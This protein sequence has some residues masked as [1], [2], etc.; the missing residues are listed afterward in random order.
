M[1]TIAENQNV[2]NHIRLQQNHVHSG[3]PP[4]GIAKNLGFPTK[5]SFTWQKQSQ[6]QRTVPTVRLHATVNFQSRNKVGMLHTHTQSIQIGLCSF[7]SLLQSNWGFLPTLWAPIQK[8]K[9][10]TKQCSA[11]PRP[12]KIISSSAWA[13]SNRTLH[14]GRVLPDSLPLREWFWLSMWVSISVFL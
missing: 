12:A 5:Q 2:F 14:L 6:Y 9:T 3:E 11:M 10:E 1:D 8:F 13:T 4:M 7:S